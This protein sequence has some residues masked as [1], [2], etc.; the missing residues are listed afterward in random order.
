MDITAP[1]PLIILGGRGRPSAG[2]PTG[3]GGQR[4][5]QGYKAAEL[6][7]AGRPLIEELV[8]RLRATGGFDPIY[9]VGPSQ[10]YEACS[11][12]DVRLIDIDSDFGRNIR[13]ATTRVMSEVDRQPVAYATADIL[14]EADDLERA[15]ADFRQSS[16]TDFWMLECRE[17]SNLDALGTSSWKPRYTI[18]GDGDDAP[19]PI[20]PGHLVIADP[21]AVRLDMIYDILE[22]AYQSRNLPIAQRRRAIALKIVAVLFRSDLTELRHARL[23]TV[24]F[25]TLWSGSRFVAQLRR[26]IHHH[27]MASLLR[28]VFIDR[29]HR[30]RYPDRHGRVA[31]LDCLS[32]ARDIDTEEEARELLTKVDNDQAQ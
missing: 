16:P 5:L 3:A 12:E 22:L 23:P 29:R 6:R 31:V 28:R 8:E 20:L 14:P 2:L 30:K 27:E 18:Q 11:L 1:V 25:D 13:A 15:L 9:L 7:V 24:T 4:I 10:V 21:W 26:G 19:V 32:L 17:P